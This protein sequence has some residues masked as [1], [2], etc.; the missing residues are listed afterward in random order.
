MEECGV[1][2]VKQLGQLM[3]RIRRI[4]REGQY[5]TAQ[6]LWGSWSSLQLR[7]VFELRSE[8]FTQLGSKLQMSLLRAG[9]SYA[10]CG[11]IAVDKHRK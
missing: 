3:E 10:I 5:K 2:V 6:S 1:V 7:C 8:Y 4:W 11:V 9:Y